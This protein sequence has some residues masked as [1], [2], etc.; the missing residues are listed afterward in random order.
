MLCAM[1]EGEP[2]DVAL[3]DWLG[4]CVALVVCEGVRVMD[5]VCV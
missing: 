2:D 1:F 4:E 5:E 3:A